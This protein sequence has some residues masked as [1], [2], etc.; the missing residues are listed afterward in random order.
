M[1]ALDISVSSTLFYATD[2]TI[3]HITYK[4][5][6]LMHWE[7]EDRSHRWPKLAL[8]YFII[9]LNLSLSLFAPFI[10]SLFSLIPSSSVSL[11][12]SLYLICIL[13]ST[14]KS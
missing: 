3:T 2:A 12:V 4:V 14:R 5:N 10:V 11:C 8:C 9:F 7:P 6:P 13:R 1:A